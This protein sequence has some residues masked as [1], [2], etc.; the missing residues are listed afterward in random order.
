MPVKTAASPALWIEQ[1]APVENKRLPELPTEKVE[2]PKRLPLRY[3]DQRIG[4]F[5]CRILGA[6]NVRSSREP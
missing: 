1:I 4:I 3:D 5:Q 2:C 6:V